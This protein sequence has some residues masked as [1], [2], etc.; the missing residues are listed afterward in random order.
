MTELESRHRAVAAD[1]FDAARQPRN[2]LVPPQPQ[3]AD[4]AAAAPV[5][6]GRFHEDE[7]GAARRIA[8][9]ID[10]MPTGPEPLSGRVR[11]HWGGD[12]A[13]LT[14]AV[15]PPDRRKHHRRP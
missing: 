8:A 5:D 2:M 12:D 4:R 1:E 15:A 9:G 6:L 7:A 3:I 13:V 10:Q 11:V 14:R